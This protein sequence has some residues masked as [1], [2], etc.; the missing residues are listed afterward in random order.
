MFEHVYSPNLDGRI[1]EE[2]T[3][4]PL[5]GLIASHRELHSRLDR[6]S[7]ILRFNLTVVAIVY[8]HMIISIPA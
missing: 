8:A 3:P 7:H 2:Y 1:A 6:F 5:V 4:S